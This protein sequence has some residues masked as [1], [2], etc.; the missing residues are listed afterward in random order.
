MAD[1][2]I[3]PVAD[4][5]DLLDRLRSSGERVTTARRAVIVE[6]V[7]DEAQHLSADQVMERVRVNHP[8]LHQSTVY[9]T[10]EFLENIGLVVRVDAGKAVA[11]YHL[12]GHG[13]HH[14]MCGRCGVLVEFDDDALAGLVEQLETLHGF[15]AHP[16]HLI[17]TGLCGSCRGLS[18]EKLT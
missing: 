15:Q 8:D 7:A 10:L 1:G 9:R 14:A 12:A 6:L 16:R 18:S 13:H 3:S 4:V 17:I 5:D 11:T 2:T